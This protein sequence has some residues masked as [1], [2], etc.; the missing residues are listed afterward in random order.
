MSTD[1]ATVASLAEAFERF[2]ALSERLATA[3][4]RLERRLAEHN[5]Q[6]AGISRARLTERREKERLA[7]RL[8]ALIEALP[9]AVILVDGRDRVDQ[10]NRA[11]ETAFEGIRWGRRWAEV[12][13]DNLASMPLED[14]WVLRCGVRVSVSVRPLGDNGMVF[15]MQDVTERRRLEQR[16]L[17]QERLSALG[18]MAARLAHQVRTP[19][20]AAVL[21]A[22][23][24]AGAELPA[25]HRQ[26][27]AEKLLARLRHTE[28]LVADMLTF[29]RGERYRPEPLDLRAVV[30]DAADIVAPRFATGDAALE[31]T[32]PDGDAAR[33]LG[34]AQAL[35]GVLVNLLT[36][37]LEHG[38][39]GVT[40]TLGMD[41]AEEGYRVFVE[42]SGKGVPESLRARVFEPFFTTRSSG[43]GLG[44]AVAHSVVTEHGGQMRCAGERGNRF[45]LVLPYGTA[46]ADQSTWRQSA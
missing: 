46:V 15:V 22:G 8:G 29:A 3:Y 11:A 27:F 36:N 17:H 42:D 25:P 13:T 9:A 26:R 43:T 6:L 33:V 21:Y 41:R 2:S 39:P 24:L 18:E 45:E 35:V 10:Y 38:G 12:L 30:R 44:L 1:A 20:S 32:V 34:N 16:L 28:Q 37:A 19:L 40:V 23:Q 4:E 31:L 14:E 5:G 7:D